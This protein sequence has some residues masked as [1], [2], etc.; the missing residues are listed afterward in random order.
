MH[1]DWYYNTV[2]R[3]NTRDLEPS[4]A[5]VEIVKYFEGFEPEAYYDSVG[6]LT[7]GFG[8]TQGVS[9]G[10]VITLEEA[11]NRLLRRLKED[12]AYAV[13]VNV[14]VP[15]TQ[16][17]FDALTCF[18]YNL[19]SGNLRRSTLLKLLNQGKYEEASDEF[20]KWSKAGGKTL[21]GLFRRRI[22]EE[23]LFE[24]DDWERFKEISG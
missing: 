18:T 21:R 4:H 2:R 16:Y 19:G 1:E 10:D 20:P 7:I 23:L 22:G 9:V 24:G 14:K 17:E 3:M 12:Y 13:Q 11:S 5:C 6:V 15:L 8:E